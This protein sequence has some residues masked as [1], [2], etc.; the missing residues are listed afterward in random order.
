MYT[1]TVP[2]GNPA[3]TGTVL[4]T[5]AISPG[6]FCSFGG[7][8]FRRKAE[9][10]I[11]P[12]G[13]AAAG[14][15]GKTKFFP[16]LFRAPGGGPVPGRPFLSLPDCTQP[17]FSV[18]LCQDCTRAPTGVGSPAPEQSG[19]QRIKPSASFGSS[20]TLVGK[21]HSFGAGFFPSPRLARK[22]REGL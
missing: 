14:S 21:I 9:I 2:A 18:A 3:G 19:R 7:V 4:R 12:V 13:D 20:V 1:R 6:D 11:I 5:P 10:T 15:R 8:L 22:G 17:S 16:D